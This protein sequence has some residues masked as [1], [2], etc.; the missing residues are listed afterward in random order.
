MEASRG[1]SRSI[2]LKEFSPGLVRPTRTEDAYLAG[3]DGSLDQYDTV[4]RADNNGFLIT[5]NF[6]SGQRKKIIILGD[7]FVESYWAPGEQDRWVSVVERYLDTNCE[8]K[9]E[10]LNGG[11]SGATSLHLALSIP[12]KHR[13]FFAETA[14]VI[15][16]VPNNDS[17]VSGLEHTYWTKDEYWSP[18]T[19]FDH[20]G[21][22]PSSSFPADLDAR[23]NWSLMLNYLK[24][25]GIPTLVVSTPYRTGHWGE[26]KFISD[27]FPD[28]E[29][30]EGWKTS[31]SKAQHIAFEVAKEYGVRTMHTALFDWPERGTSPYFYDQL[32]LNTQGQHFFGER[33]AR[34]L[35]DMRFWEE[36]PTPLTSPL[37]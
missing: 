14:G 15:L 30:F 33:F 22:L 34:A 32:H 25:Y 35:L 18:L 23:A 21:N 9:F 3:T 36:E 28:E 26:D 37:K 29:S 24:T 27:S 1:A 31:R 5:G 17:V 10:V 6:L 2:R 7:S 8:N 13:A 4:L 11:Y 12:S 16:F 20:S 19:P